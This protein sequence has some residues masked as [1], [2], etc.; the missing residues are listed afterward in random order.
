MEL[1]R[2]GGGPTLIEAKTYRFTGHSK[3][4]AKTT[5]Y[6]PEEEEEEWKSRDPIPALR[7]YI[8]HAGIATESGELREI[9]DR[10]LRQVEE[11]TE[12]ALQAPVADPKRALQGVYATNGATI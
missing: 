3:S 6:R 7:N 12:F 8:L 1:A 9:E 5:L 10:V 2:T 4:D 11:A